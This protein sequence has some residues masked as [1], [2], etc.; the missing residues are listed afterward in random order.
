MPDRRAWSFAA[1]GA[2]LGLAAGLAIWGGFP[3][4]TAAAT[5]PAAVQLTPVTAPVVG[6]LAPEF[7]A[8]ELDGDVF[9][10][11]QARGRIVLL[12][13]WAT[14]CDPC[15]AEMPLLQARS[16][17]FESAGLQVVGVN[18]D[19]PENEVRAFQDE[20]GLTFRIVLD[21]GG[22]VQA[23]YKVLGYPTTF[24]VDEVGVI[25]FVH[26]GSMDADQLDGYLREMGLG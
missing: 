5:S 9:R 18:F 21:P 22:Q 24:F 2:L 6:G 23:L 25:R 26:I 10:L 14:W 19:E 1:I 13:F 16:R 15:R 8:A 11:S 4:S 17:D 20:L 12:N 3:E 7:E